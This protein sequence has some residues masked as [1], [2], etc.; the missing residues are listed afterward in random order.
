MHAKHEMFSMRNISF[1]VGLGFVL[2]GMTLAAD[3]KCDLVKD[4][5]YKHA[6]IVWYILVFVLIMYTM[7]ELVSSQ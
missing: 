4:T 5:R 3:D 2:F 6:I 1:W 7:V